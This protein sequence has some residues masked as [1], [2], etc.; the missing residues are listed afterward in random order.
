MFRRVYGSFSAFEYP[1]SVRE[2]TRSDATNAQRQRLKGLS[3]N[4]HAA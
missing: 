4:L 1:D 3:I 2:E